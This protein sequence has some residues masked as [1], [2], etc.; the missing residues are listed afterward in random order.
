MG[1]NTHKE[2]AQHPW[3]MDSDDTYR[4]YERM[5]AAG[6]TTVCV[7]KGL[8]GR[9]AD[10]RFPELAPYADAVLPDIGY[11]PGWLDRRAAG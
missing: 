4:G 6:V 1:D 8:W 5:L 9:A 11:L 2:T 3:R 10:R 7:H